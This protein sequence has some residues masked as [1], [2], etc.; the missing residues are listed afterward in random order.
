[1]R[2]M[3]AQCTHLHQRISWAE[4]GNGYFMISQ[5]VSEFCFF[6]CFVD[7]IRKKERKISGRSV[8]CYGGKLCILIFEIQCR[9]VSLAHLVCA[10]S[11]WKLS[12]TFF[13][14]G[15]QCNERRSRLVL[16]FRVLIMFR[17]FAKHI[18]TVAWTRAMFTLN[19]KRQSEALTCSFV[20]ILH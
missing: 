9:K 11:Q 12:N 6:F 8:M 16:W 18:S 13:L 4:N 2:E 5:C 14:F 17:F 20:C 10:E 19:M 7:F 3:A 1:M 15:F